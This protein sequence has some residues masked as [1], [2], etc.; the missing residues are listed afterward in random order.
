MTFS[1]AAHGEGGEGG[2][3]GGGSGGGG[4][5]GSGAAWPASVILGVHVLQSSVTT[6]LLHFRVK[7]PDEPATV[8]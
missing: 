2:E 5:T 8:S 7:I 3:G 1:A 4:G 6:D